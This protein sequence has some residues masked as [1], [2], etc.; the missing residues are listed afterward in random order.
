[1]LLTDC[2]ERDWSTYMCKRKRR[3]SDKSH[4]SVEEHASSDHAHATKVEAKHWSSVGRLV[5]RSGSGR[6]AR[7]ARDGRDGR[8]WLRRSLSG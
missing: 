8:G 2:E 4:G 7:S 5:S 1:M 3:L 6:G